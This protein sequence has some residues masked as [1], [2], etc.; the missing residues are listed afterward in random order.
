MAFPG[1]FTGELQI[2]PAE[3]NETGRFRT[4]EN[5]AI[6]PEGRTSTRLYSLAEP[7]FARLTS[8]WAS[9]P[10]NWKCLGWPDFNSW[11]KFS[12]YMNL[13]N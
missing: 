6:E 4:I 2:G 1:E 3:E 8:E 5:P 12:Q 10:L 11:P 7:V 9:M 13:I